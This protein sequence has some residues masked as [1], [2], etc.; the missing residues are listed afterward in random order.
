MYEE[1]MIIQ[2][3][4]R[5]LSKQ[6]KL[7]KKKILLFGYNT[8]TEYIN[9]VLYDE[10]YTLYKIIDNDK[11]K[12]GKRA[13][14]IQIVNPGNINWEDKYVVL[15][16]SSHIKE[17]IFQIQQLAEN[18]EIFN[19]LDFAE[20][21][22]NVWKKDKFWLDENYKTEIEKLYLGFE[23]YNKLKEDDPLV[24]FP[25]TALGDIFVGGLSFPEYMK[26]RNLKSIKVVVSSIGA[27]KV[28][29]LFKIKNTTIISEDK[30]DAL[31]KF[32]FFS[33]VGKEDIICS[34]GGTF[35]FMS[36]YMKIPFAKYCAK[37]FF[38]LGNEYKMQFPCI[39]DRNLDEIELENKGLVKEKT[40]ILAP[41]ANT[42][43][44]L[45]FQFWEHLAKRLTDLKYVLITNV[46]S[47]QKPVKGSLGLEIPLNQIGSYLEYAGYFISI[48]SG[49]CDV[50]GR[51]NCKQ[52]I[53]FRDQKCG[54]QTTL[55]EMYDLHS[56]GI[57]PNAI[58][59]LYDENDFF[60][61]IDMVIE[62]LLYVD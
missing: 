14:T 53:I 46:I 19:L 12:H 27:Y 18:T 20:Y 32:I 39:V 29:Q 25:P 58:Q 37:F 6:K 2:N 22:K 44:E 15:I 47:N 60:K 38:V 48:R 8:Y 51:S 62:S 13:F 23:T 50:V 16:A 28:V 40:V 45:P 42:V 30:M 10:G 31:V 4:I 41:Y 3:N 5:K 49:L 7:D 59:C 11:K 34:W 52:I 24:I 55:I 26:K 35:W 54:F 17:M 1:K 56:E 36:T 43:D 61:T 9:N 57:S 21:K 33:N